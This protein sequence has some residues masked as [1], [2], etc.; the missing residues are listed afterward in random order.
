MSLFTVDARTLWVQRGKPVTSDGFQESGREMIGRMLQT[1][2]SDGE[3]LAYDRLDPDP[4]PKMQYADGTGQ[5]FASPRFVGSR[6]TFPDGVVRLLSMKFVY[7]CA[8]H[9]IVQL[10]IAPTT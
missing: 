9:G 1:R 5:L 6:G 4:V 7:A 10:V 8:Q 3:M 2:I